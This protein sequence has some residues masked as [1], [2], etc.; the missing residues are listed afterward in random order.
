[1]TGY[2]NSTDFPTTA[3]APYRTYGGGEFDAFLAK[4][5]TTGTTYDLQVAKTGDGSGSVTSNPSGIECGD[6]CSFDFDGG[7]NVTLTAAAQAGSQF[8]GWSGGGCSGTGT[9]TVTL[10][11]FGE[12]RTNS[13]KTLG[14]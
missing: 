8:P 14:Q 7:T 4:V 13:P 10:N 6:A 3:G 2:T 5:T 9:C 1:M 11:A 12:L